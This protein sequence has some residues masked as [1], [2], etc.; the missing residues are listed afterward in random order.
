MRS[1]FR[2]AGVPST[3]D[4]GKASS[5]GGPSNR[6]MRSGFAENSFLAKV[7]PGLVPGTEYSGGA[8]GP[9]IPSMGGE[10]TRRTLAPRVLFRDLR[11]TTPQGPLLAWPAPP[12]GLRRRLPRRSALERDRFSARGTSSVRVLSVLYD[13]C[14]WTRAHNERLGS[15]TL[16]EPRWHWQAGGNSCVTVPG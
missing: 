12:G 2:S 16:A 3:R 14:E 8:S 10:A 5:I 13:V 6:P 15:V 11:R 4:A 1:A 7:R 9:S